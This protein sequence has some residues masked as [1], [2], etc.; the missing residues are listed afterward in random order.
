MG[1]NARFSAGREP[2]TASHPCSF[3]TAALWGEIPAALPLS[4]WTVKAYAVS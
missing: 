4:L 2:D 1:R 3:Y